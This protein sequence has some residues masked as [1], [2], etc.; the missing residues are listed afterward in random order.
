VDGRRARAL[1]RDGDRRQ[2]LARGMTPIPEWR[3]RRF[4][5]RTRTII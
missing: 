5:A 1:P 2:G 3:G 4:D